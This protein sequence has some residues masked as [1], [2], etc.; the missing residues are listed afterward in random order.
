LVLFYELIK[1]FSYGLLKGL[2][3]KNI[4]IILVHYHQAQIT[5]DCLESLISSEYQ[6]FNVIIIDNGSEKTDQD[7]IKDH[8]LENEIQFHSLR[9]KNIDLQFD[10]SVNWYVAPQNLGYAGGM[11]LGSEIA[12]VGNPDYLLLLNNDT[13]VPKRFLVD[14]LAGL[15]PIADRPDFGFVG[16]LI[17]SWSDK[18]VWYA[19][20]NLNLIRCMGE[21]FDTP[22]HYSVTVE[23]G[24]LTGCCLLCRPDVYRQLNGMDEDFFLYLEDVDLC[25]RA[26]KQGYK[27]F[28][29]PSAQLFHRVGSSTGGDEKPLSVYYSSKNRI[30]MM[31]KHFNS[32]VLYRFYA[33]FFFSRIIKAMKWILLGKTKL[34]VSLCI[35][36]R[37]GLSY[38]R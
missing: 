31:R 17:R 19:G 5:W 35:G 15:E 18:T 14:F 25:Y 16:C 34:V 37:D 10:K 8:C 1:D 30:L 21:H 13:I 3:K 12:A 23:T 6:H 2:V 33:F 4:S 11:N 29:V 28:F 24:F 20:G 38:K 36:V 22:P 7:M 27:L 32:L 9:N 26:I